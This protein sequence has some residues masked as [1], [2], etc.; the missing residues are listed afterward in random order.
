MCGKIN[1]YQ[2][3]G[4]ILR[5]SG[6]LLPVFSLHSDYG[7]GTLGKHA[8][9]FVDF[10]HSSGQSL[11]QILPL[12][13]TSYGNSPYQS[14][15]VF[16]GNPYFIDPEELCKDGLIDKNLLKNLK[17]E[18]CGLVDYAYLYKNRLPLLKKVALNISD[19][20]TEYLDFCERESF[21]LEK[22]SIF[23]AL[24]E[25]NDMLPHTQ[26]KY[27][28]ASDIASLKSSSA[29]HSKIQYLFFSQWLNLKK[30][31]ND[32]GIAIIGDLPIYPA[33][34][35][36]D[37]YFSPDMFL[38]STLAA[39]PPDSFNINGQLWGNPVYDWKKMKENGYSWWKERL[40]NA[41]LLYDSI[42]IDHFRGFYEYYSVK[43]GM[44]AKDGKWTKGPGL[45]FCRMVRENFPT[46][47]IIA[48]DLGFL[49]EDTRRFFRES[50]FDG[51][52]VMLFAFDEKNSEYLPHNHIKNS[53]VYTGTHDTPTVLGWICQSDSNTLTRAMDYLGA[54]SIYTLCDY[55]IRSAF[56]SVAYRA[57]IPLQDWMKIGCGGRINTP[58]L[59]GKNWE[60]RIKDGELTKNLIEKILLY[61]KIYNR[62]L[63]E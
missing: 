57:I 28:S 58:G 2:K 38:E 62:I 40:K 51:M 3:G 13:P 49:T 16:A 10:L 11:W 54:P 31:A 45:S 35:S 18:N 12:T 26:W 14:P 63:E 17:Q 5:K 47:D 48:E 6:I 32:K 23:T 37:Y 60:W 42:R 9:E 44:S 7:I 21:W 22:Y 43:E 20:D 27:K 19:S 29:I 24:K 46:L 59:T 25:K 50:T 41:A 30:Y 56:S 8:Y 53:V 36:S 39:C 1:T 34:D 15:S 61:T 52:K 4:E 33:K 55:F